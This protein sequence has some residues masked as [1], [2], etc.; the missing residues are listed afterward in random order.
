MGRIDIQPEDQ[1]IFDR[2][3]SHGR[4]DHALRRLMTAQWNTCSVCDHIMF[5]GRPLFAG[6]SAEAEPIV[7]GACCAGRLAELSTPIYPHGTLNLA[8]PDHARLWRYMDFA[9][10]VTLLDQ[11]G[12]YFP[13]ADTLED[14]FEGAIGIA[15]REQAWDDHY[16]A[17]FREIV[18]SGMPDNP[19][20]HLTPEII[21]ADARR[22][23]ADMKSANH[24]SRSMLVSCWHAN[25]G[26]SEALWRLYCPPPIAGVAIR[27]SGAALWNATAH[28]STAV[29]GRVHYVDF[30]TSFAS[31]EQAIFCKRSSLSHEREVRA[32]L[33]NDPD[34][35]VFGKVLSCDLEQLI[36]S[37]VV[38]PFAP[39]W[40]LDT[41]VSAVRSYGFDLD[42]RG[43]ELLEPP[44]Y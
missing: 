4:I 15:S 38:S 30:R 24:R 28:E 36:D 16:V 42:V 10:F 26:E 2:L 31:R 39:P 1:A 6:Y 21:E 25:S 12:L 19:V 41:V 7:A 29:V 35:P 32:V 33:T 40:F 27:S 8:V 18:E 44:F 37:V 22:L 3:K 14:R 17:R 11:K 43:S 9:K 34:A 13:R 23:L 20:P 5:P